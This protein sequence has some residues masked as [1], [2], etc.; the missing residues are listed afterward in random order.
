M[1]PLSQLLQLSNCI[2]LVFS[3]ISEILQEYFVFSHFYQI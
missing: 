3:K 1:K 2:S